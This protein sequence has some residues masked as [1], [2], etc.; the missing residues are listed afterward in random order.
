[1]TD[2]LLTDLRGALGGRLIS[3]DDEQAFAAARERGW[4]HDLAR[5]VNPLGFVVV[6]GVSDIVDAVNYCRENGLRVA[7][8]GKGAHSPWG[9]IEDA[10]VIDLMRM[11]AV[12]VDPER[13]LAHIQAGA[14]GG[15]VD[16][17]T[18]RHDLVC[19]TGSVSHTG[20]AGVAL[21]GGI[22]HLSRWL[23]PV[24]DSIVGYEMVTARGEVVRIDAASDP[25]LFWGMRGN[26]A[27]FGVVTEFVVKLREMP[28]GGIVRSAP[29]LWPED[30]AREVMAAW[31]KR[32]AAPGRPDTETLQ[33]VRMHAP[34]GAP[35]CAVVPLIVGAG[36]DAARD[37]CDEI[38][39]YAGGAVARQDTEMPYTALQTALDGFF[40][41][42]R[43]Y[44]DKGVFIDWDPGDEGAVGRIID[45]MA[46]AWAARPAFALKDSTFL[47]MMEVGGAIGRADPAS[48][49]FAARAGRLWATALIAWPD[50][51][52]AQRAASK[53]WCDDMVA[54]LA[55]FHASAYVNNA[56]PA[57]DA[58][59]RAVFPDATIARLRRLKEKH[60]PEGLFRSG[61]WDYAANV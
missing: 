48:T 36:G 16:R 38:A 31:M 27:S 22:G 37:I 26:G 2:V 61:A 34:D 13:K 8:R 10:I 59:M 47:L 20:F 35:V 23:G 17:E 49:S 7:V 9:M 5:R 14:D 4:N 32:V 29:I 54:A 42:G 57:S 55:P 46:E 11:T 39:A 43:N 21:G 25:E 6:D 30:K 15:D 3:R 18:A 33:L 28:N 45:T 12:R 56:M 53:R 44:W 24:V 50:D 19:V 58:E 60:D 1:M 41:Y 40:P 51:D 52:D